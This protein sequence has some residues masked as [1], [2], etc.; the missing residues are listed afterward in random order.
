DPRGDAAL[1]ANQG[2]A[3]IV[4]VDPRVR[5]R[6]VVLRRAR[7]EGRVGARI[8]PSGARVGIPGRVARE[9]RMGRPLA[10]PPGHERG[11]HEDAP[12]RG[13]ESKLPRVDHP[14]AHERHGS[15]PTMTSGGAIEREEA[16]LRR[17]FASVLVFAGAC[18]SAKAP[19]APDACA[20]QPIAVDA[21]VTY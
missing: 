2:G 21:Q 8:G 1:V 19:D 12:E 3:R 17:I 16:R 20:P 18:R 11:E 9:A 13:A 15:I 4:R 5:G 6:D 14:R 10:A 7:I